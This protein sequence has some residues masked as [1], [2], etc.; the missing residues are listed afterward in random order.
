M[1]ANVTIKALSAA[2]L[3]L[4]GMA[5]AGGAMAECPAGT[6]LNDPAVNWT[7]R[8]VSGSGVLGLQAPG[9]KSTAC[10]MSSQLAN[11]AISQAVVRDGTPANETRYRFRFYFD[12]ATVAMTGTQ[13]VQVFAAN[14][15]NPATTG[16]GASTQNILRI[17][18]TP[19]SGG[20]NRLT[21]IANTTGATQAPVSVPLVAGANVVEGEILIGPDTGPAQSQGTVRIWVNNNVE[22]TPTQTITGL[23]NTAWVGVKFA[24]LGLANGSSAFRASHAAKDVFFDEFDSRRTTFIGQ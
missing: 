16:G 4:A 8:L 7:T 20:G 19:V 13:Q 21:F 5:F 24:A 22:A 9:M 10:K 11:N 2:V 14:S 23:N 1:K 6:G 17:N 12:P 18:M 15:E 3:G